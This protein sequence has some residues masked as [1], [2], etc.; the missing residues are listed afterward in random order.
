MTCVY[1][2]IKRKRVVS[3][4]NCTRKARKTQLGKKKAP[5]GKKNYLD[6]VLIS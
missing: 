1:T 4:C 6:L 5:D 3:L 2:N